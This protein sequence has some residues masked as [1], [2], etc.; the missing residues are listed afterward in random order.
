MGNW[1]AQGVRKAGFPTIHVVS[2]SLGKTGTE[3]AT[4]VAAL[5]GDTTPA[6]E[7]LSDVSD[8]GALSDTLEEHF[9]L[10]LDIFGAEASFV[11]FYTLVEREQRAAI[12]AFA[13]AH[14]QVTVVDLLDEAIDALRTATGKQPTGRPGALRTVDDAYFRRIE[15]MEF[16]IAHD[17]GARPEDLTKADIVLVGVSR[18][19]KTPLSIY[20]SQQGY[21]VANIPLDPKT[22]PPA[23]VFDVERMRLFGLMTSPEVL[24]DIR[25]RRLAKAA[26]GTNVAS[27]YADY[28]SVCEDL[29]RARA[30]MRKLGCIVVRTDNKAIEETAQEILRYYTPFF[31]NQ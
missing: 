3:I 11:V 15:A 23:Q 24:V 1:I 22:D 21:K 7:I 5:F 27:S 9:A 18:S 12:K 13:A 8:A 29:E 10:H 30:L 20:L 25:R 16:T 2:D 4:A 14:D 19:S 6:L 31:Q 28:E 17:D 26:A